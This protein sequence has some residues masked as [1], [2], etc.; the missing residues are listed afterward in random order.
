MDPM[1][2]VVPFR[3]LQFKPWSRIFIWHQPKADPGGQREPF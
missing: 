3:A 1:N 2:H